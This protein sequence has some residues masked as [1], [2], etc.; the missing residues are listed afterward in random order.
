MK[1][2]YKY[3]R[4]ECFCRGEKTTQ[5]KIVNRRSGGELGEIKWYSAWRQYCFFTSFDAVFNDSCLCDIIHFIGQL[6]AARNIERSRTC[7]QQPQHA[8]T[9]RD[10]NAEM[11]GS[12][13]A[14]ILGDDYEIGNK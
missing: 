14:D 10:C 7:V 5:W 4:F 13:D 1:T 8:I 6:S 2:E 3:I 12:L 9:N 11:V